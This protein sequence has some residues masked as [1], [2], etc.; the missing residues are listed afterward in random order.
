MAEITPFVSQRVITMVSGGPHGGTSSVSH[1]LIAGRADVL[2]AAVI[3]LKV[4]AEGDTP[5]L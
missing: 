5:Y 1:P 2:P 3:V 4:T